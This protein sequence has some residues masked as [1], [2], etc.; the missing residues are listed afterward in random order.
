MFPG[1]NPLALDLMEKCLAFS[2]KRRL[3]VK[4]ALKHPYL[5]PYHDLEDEPTADTIDP[6]F[7]DFD[8]GEAMSTEQL[9]GSLYCPFCSILQLTTL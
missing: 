4:E 7:F 8:T 1:V 2:P 3:D 9:K 6:S 5:Q